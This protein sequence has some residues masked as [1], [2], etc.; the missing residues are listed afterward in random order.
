MGIQKLIAASILLIA[1]VRDDARAAALAHSEEN[2]RAGNR[3]H[4]RQSGERERPAIGRSFGVCESNQ[5]FQAP[6]E[7][8][9]TDI[10][11]NFRVSGLEPAT[12][13][14]IA[15]THLHTRQFPQIRLR[16]LTTASAI[17]CEWR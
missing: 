17:R 7:R 6:D 13:R 3:C 4:R 10:D 12:L 2:G 11:G 8:T 15:A 16:R 1:C 9:T 5:Y 14:H